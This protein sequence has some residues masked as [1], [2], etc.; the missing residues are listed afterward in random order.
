M[1]KYS[2]ITIALLSALSGVVLAA[3][4]TLNP[5]DDSYVMETQPND[6]F[7]NG[8]YGFVGSYDNGVLYGTLLFDLSPYSGVTVN[9]ASLQL[10]IA[11]SD[12]TFLPNN[13]WIARLSGSWDEGTITWNNQPGWDEW[14][15][16]ADA[17]PMFDWWDIDITTWTI[18][19][20]NGSHD[21]YG[22]FLGAE[23]L[24]AADWFGYRTKEYSGTT[25]D[26][27]LELDYTPT[28]IESASLGEIKAAFK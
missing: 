12:G 1:F 13:P 19:W 15:Y 6:N 8:N 3:T 18:A 28:S 23:S 21:N 26:P 16:T 7:G 10:Y 2:V 9:D 20:V 24:G 25:Y 5:T 17:P 27:R 22:A 4:A 14:Y 11:H